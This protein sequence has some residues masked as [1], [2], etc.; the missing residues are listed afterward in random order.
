MKR[1]FL[2]S[3]ALLR[4][5]ALPKAETL[6]DDEKILQH[7]RVEISF[8]F[9]DS[10]CKSAQYIVQKTLE[11]LSTWEEDEIMIHFDEDD[12]TLYNIEIDALLCREDIADN[13]ALDYP[14]VELFHDDKKLFLPSISLLTR[15]RGPLIM[16][17]N[18][19]GQSFS[20]SISVDKLNLAFGKYHMESLRIA[21]SGD[22]LYV[23]FDRDDDLDISTFTTRQR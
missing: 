2:K 8:P 18:N 7:A 22:L 23:D 1:D 11:A 17:S 15:I 19:D 12:S 14:R 16:L 10:A 20:R 21:I 4:L 6:K 5:P 3:A 13:K 9:A